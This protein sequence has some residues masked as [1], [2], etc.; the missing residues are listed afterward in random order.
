MKPVLPKT[1]AWILLA[2]LVLLDA[3]LDVIFAQGKGIETNVLKPIADLLK[4]TNPIF[5]TPIVLVVF[6]FVVKFGVWITKKID[7]ISVKTE[8]LVLTTLVIVY[9]VFDL[10][11][12]LVYF[13]KFSLIKN[14][15][16]LIPFLIIIGTV[17]NWWAEKKLK[18]SPSS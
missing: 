18:K 15:L 12:V 14:H 5:L 3:S 11:L 7:K 9:G 16:Y 13:F 4:I 8:E 10:W 2:F 17:Y 6:Y 1:L